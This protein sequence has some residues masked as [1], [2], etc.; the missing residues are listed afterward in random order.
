MFLYSQTFFLKRL[1]SELVRDDATTGEKDCIF[2]GLKS[3]S[4]T[5]TYKTLEPY[6]VGFINKETFIQ[7]LLKPL[8]KL[9]PDAS[10]PP[11]LKVGRGSSIVSTQ[12]NENISCLRY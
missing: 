10:V 12:K 4:A 5:V 6:P 8:R 2:K 11:H 1:N 3:G 7:N 9:G